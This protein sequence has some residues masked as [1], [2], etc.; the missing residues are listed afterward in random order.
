MFAPVLGAGVQPLWSRLY[1]TVSQRH[2][3]R[4]RTAIN[5]ALSTLGPVQLGEDPYVGAQFAAAFI[6]GTIDA[7]Q[8]IG[9]NYTVSAATAKHFFG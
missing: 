9:Y 5:T 7:A 2:R 8:T 3:R 1:E 6:Q 4:S